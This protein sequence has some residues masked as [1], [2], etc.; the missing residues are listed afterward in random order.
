MAVPASAGQAA[1]WSIQAR[2]SA[3]CSGGERVLVERH[4][5][6]AAL[7][8]DALQEVALRAVAGHQ[9]R[10]GGAALQRQVAHVQP[11]LAAPLLLAVALV[12]AATRR[13]GWICVAKSTVGAGCA[14][15]TTSAASHAGPPWAE[16][17]GKDESWGREPS[18]AS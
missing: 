7:A 17:R 2:M 11:Q 12:A 10:A 16:R 6:F 1:P 4:A 14:E 3:V 13:M 15:G 8:E 9:Q 5:V 18:E